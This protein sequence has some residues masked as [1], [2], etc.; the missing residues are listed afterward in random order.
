VAPAA[1]DPWLDAKVATAR[2]YAEQ[3]LPQAVGLGPAVVRG[4]AALD[5]GAWR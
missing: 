4:A 5:P 1:P 3:I 2:F